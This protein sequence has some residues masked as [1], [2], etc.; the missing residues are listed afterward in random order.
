MTTPDRIS[1][2]GVRARGRHG[3]LEQERRD[4]QDFLVDLHLE[5]DL[6][7]AGRS[8]DLAE[9]VNYADVAA[10]AVAHVAGEPVDLIETLATR[11]A[12][13]VLARDLVEAVEVVV[14]K[15]QAPVGHPFSDVTVRIRRERA[16]PVVIALGANLGEAP[17]T[18]T[19]AVR[20]LSVTP[21]VTVDAVSPLVDSD[22]VGGP[23]QPAYVNAVVLATVRRPARRLLEDLHRIEDRHGRVRE[24]RWGPRTLDLDLIQYGTPDGPTEVRSDDPDLTLPHPRA[25]ERAF[26]LV[27]WEAVDPGALLRTPDGVR[28]VTDLVGSV[29]RSGVR[30]TRKEWRPSW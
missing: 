29:D 7:A 3:V 9:T 17:A 16:V 15:P 14:H 30:I 18:L 26:V 4:G 20:D 8:D 11:I 5:V 1:L 28:R 27:P 24:V 6:T 21:G 13:D 22:P 19:A 25:H 23:Q 12:D 2:T 10:V